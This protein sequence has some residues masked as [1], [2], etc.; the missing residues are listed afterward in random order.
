[1]AAAD[2]SPDSMGDPD[3]TMPG[4]DHWFARDLAGLYEEWQP[5]PA[6]EPTLVA[7]NTALAIELGL[8]P[9]AL[10]SAEGLAVFAG[11]R[12][13]NGAVPIAMGYAGHQFGGYSPRLGDGRALLLGEVVMADGS[14]RDVHLKG[15]GRTPFARGG[16][17]KAAIG[18]MLREYLIAEAMHALGVP[19]TRALAV[20]ATGEY[21]MRDAA[22][23][24]AVLTRIAA[25]HIRVGT[26]EYA[27]RLEDRTAIVRLADHAITRHHPQASAADN[28]YLALLE[29]VVE[30]QASLV[31]QWMLVGFIHG[32]MN[33]DNMT[34]S[35]EGID[36][37]PC[38]FMDRYDPRTVY[39]SID[40]AGRYAYGNQPNIAQWNLARLAETLLSLIDDDAQAAVARATEVLDGFA[41]RFDQHWHQGMRAK[42]GLGSTA[43][44]VRAEPDIDAA[45]DREC[46]AGWL[47]LLGA[48]T[49]DYT[50][51]YRALADVLRGD[52]APLHA[53]LG[54]GS[55]VHRWLATWQPRVAADGVAA[56]DRAAAMDRVNP[57]FIPRNHH[58]ERV[59][60]AATG[61]DF[62]PFEEMLSV[63][64]SPFDVQPG[65][66]AF[67]GPATVE[68]AGAHQT[69]CG[70]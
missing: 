49:A 16:D 44:A 56:L 2:D 22:L 62:V 5:S 10:A 12:V 14:H 70:T 34:I 38:A 1:M 65:R 7:L 36:Y 47:E 40:H 24:G 9:T 35:G 55:D 63:V 48:H 45:G 66:E 25:S 52:S 21:V 61:G 13:P 33:T 37:G 31:A 6:P 30:A 51:S 15:S 41:G 64:T 20:T 50:G 39:S 28:P 57:L 8:D 27:A 29:A 43:A 42:L 59:L 32:V 69:F 18:P 26:F 60:A 19:T 3:A 53:L 4:L 58:V 46:I 68:F 23:P 67:A 11:N 17:G 54:D